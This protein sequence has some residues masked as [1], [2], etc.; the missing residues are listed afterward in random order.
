MLT[1]N[2]RGLV[3]ETAILHECVKLGV[4]VSRPLDDEPYGLILDLRPTLLR[5][6]CKSARLHE[7]VVVI[8][9]KRCRRGRDGLIHRTYGEGEIDAIAA[10]CAELDTSYLLPPEMSVGRAAV[11]LRIK[12]C[13]NNQR[14]GINWARDY[15]LGATLGRL[16]GPIAQLGER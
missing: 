4:G 15:D 7:D 5:V 10:Y 8:R 13:R 3:A 16:R 12:P 9:C 1:T 14:A 6:Q 2:Q 11:Q